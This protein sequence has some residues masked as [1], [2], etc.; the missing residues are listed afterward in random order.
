M[1]FG[2]EGA[3]K[4]VESGQDGAPFK[5]F[6]SDASLRQPAKSPIICQFFERGEC[7]RGDNCLYSHS[8]EDSQAASEAINTAKAER[9]ARTD[10]RQAASTSLDLISGTVDAGAIMSYGVADTARAPYMGGKGDRLPPS[11]KSVY[12]RF[13]DTGRCHRGTTCAYA[14]GLHELRGTVLGPDTA[15]PSISAGTLSAKGGRLGK[16][17]TSPGFRTSMTYEGEAQRL[18]INAVPTQ[19]EVMKALQTLFAAGFSAGGS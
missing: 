12:C 18:D 2:G 3:A 7:S 8:V 1:G 5:R 19:P 14:H 11:F 10:F 6:R 4:M 15:G 17:G 16:G 9:A 13:F